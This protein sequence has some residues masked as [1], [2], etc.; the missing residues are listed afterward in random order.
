MGAVI[1]SGLY[2]AA[3]EVCICVAGDGALNHWWTE[4]GFTTPFRIAHC[5]LAEGEIFTLSALHKVAME[6]QDSPYLYIHTKGVANGTDL[7]AIDEWRRYMTHFCVTQWRKCVEIISQGKHP[8]VGVDWREEPAPHFSGNFW[9]ADGSYLASLKPARETPLVLT[10]RHKAEFWIGTGRPYFSCLHD[11][12]ADVYHREKTRLPME[13][14]DD[15]LAN[16]CGE[17]LRQREGENMK[18]LNPNVLRKHILTMI[19]KAQSGHI[20]ASFSI[21]ELIA[22]LY[23]NFR[24]FV[25]DERGHYV[26]TED[27]DRIVLSKGHAVPAIYAALY[28]LGAIASLD[29]FREIDS[30]LQGHPDSARFPLVH[31]S[32][33]SL[34][35]G[36]SIA[37]GHALAMQ[38]AGS[39]RKVFCI[40][41]DGELDE[42]Q[43]KEGMNLAARLNLL[44]LYIIIDWN[45]RQLEGNLLNE[46]EWIIYEPNRV[47]GS[48][49]PDIEAKFQR[50]F[51]RKPIGCEDLHIIVLDTQK[52]AGISFMAGDNKW[53]S[54]PPTKEEY[55]AACKELDIKEAR[56]SC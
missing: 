22:Y 24:F 14:F 19:Y 16:A 52:A 31:A 10:E 42:G 15:R 2:E 33:G 38:L 46:S 55:D 21:C 56:V 53:H 51:A 43:I 50:L 3:E 44:N 27:C 49:I 28:E 26:V 41:G 48:S 18:R 11:S 40:L 30:P 1:A 23:S 39:K 5:S 17:I 29:S 36:L 35:Q 45:K 25:M 6:H 34:G 13:S 7:P 32:S 47:D 8:V 54:T 12:G 37:V 9:W 20:G 4:L